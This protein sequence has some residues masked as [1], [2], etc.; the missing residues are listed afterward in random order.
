MEG[1]SKNQFVNGYN[2][3]ENEEN[4]LIKDYV[5]ALPGS[6]SFYQ[7]H[8]PILQF[9]HKILGQKPAK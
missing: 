2:M 1:F 4:S 8:Y 9:F 7:P 5:R 6:L 3:R